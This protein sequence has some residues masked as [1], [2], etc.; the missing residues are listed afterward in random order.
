ML[1]LVMLTL[2]L[3]IF[4]KSLVMFPSQMFP[5]NFYGTDFE[6]FPVP[7][8]EIFQNYCWRMFG[9]LIRNFLLNFYLVFSEFFNSRKMC[10]NTYSTR[11]RTYV[12]GVFGLLIIFFLTWL[13]CSKRDT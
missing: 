12:G 4:V 6:K 13:F 1:F 3:I 11:T 2:N 8:S 10:S 9:K 5:V 7:V